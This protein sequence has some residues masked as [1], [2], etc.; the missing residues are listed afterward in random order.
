M[1]NKPQIPVIHTPMLQG[2]SG[3]DRDLMLAMMAAL[4]S[5]ATTMIGVNA[6]YHRLVKAAQAGATATQSAEMQEALDGLSLA[7]DAEVN[8]II[9]LCKTAKERLKPGQVLRVN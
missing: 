5:A 8:S 4:G 7:M 6:S 9:E 1:S 3:A 2:L